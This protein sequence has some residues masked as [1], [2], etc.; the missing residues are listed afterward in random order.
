MAYVAINAQKLGEANR[1]ANLIRKSSKRRYAQAYIAWLR[2]GAE[3]MEPT[4]TC[5]AIDRAQ[6]M[7]AIGAMK[8]WEGVTP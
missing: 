8:L 2:N 4:W 5:S 3:G 7:L 6:V 1:Y